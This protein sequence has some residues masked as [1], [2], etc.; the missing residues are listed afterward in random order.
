MTDSPDETRAVPPPEEDPR[1]GD[2]TPLESTLSE[3]ASAT[4]R[5]HSGALPEKIGPYRILER[6]GEGGFGTVYRAEQRGAIRRQVAVKVIKAGMDTK[7]VL[8]RFDAEKNALSLMNHPNI[9]RVLDSG[10]T[11]EGRPYFAMEYV[12][13]T[14]FTGQMTVTV[15]LQVAT[16]M[17]LAPPNESIAM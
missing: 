17:T 1:A 3:P 7:Q 9:A 11:D 10:Q 2:S 4:P 15:T 12:D 16:P 13:G 6:L 5:P 8:A 14:P